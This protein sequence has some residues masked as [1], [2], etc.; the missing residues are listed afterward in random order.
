[1]TCTHCRHEFCWLCMKEYSDTHYAIYNV[2]GC[3][4]ME[5]DTDRTRKLQNNKCIKFLWLILSCFLGLFGIA[6]VLLF[7]IVAGCAYEFVKCYIEKKDDQ[8]EQNAHNEQQQSV[9][10][11]DRYEIKMEERRKNW[12]MIALMIL[13]GIM[14]QPI[15]LVFYMLYGMMECYRRFNCWFYYAN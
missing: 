15:Y 12:K 2:S 8:D 9:D 6:F 13:L 1:M 14:C 11:I 3:P 4:G 7:F 10:E 5:F